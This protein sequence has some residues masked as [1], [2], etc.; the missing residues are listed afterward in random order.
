MRYAKFLLGSNQDVYFRTPG[1]P[2]LLILTGV[3][4][5]DS[6]LGLML[7]QLAM[8]VLMPLLVYRIIAMYNQR[9]GY[10]AA[11]FSIA[12]LV[13]YGFMKAVLTEEL[14]MFALLLAMWVA[15]R[16]FAI[17]LVRYIYV[18]SIIFFFLLLI[19]PVAQYMFAIFL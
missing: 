17:K 19:R 1:Y 4:T 12:S 2:L 9:V 5:F 18:G 11:L 10:Y 16:F 8:G 6:F 14:Y 15:A 13:P 3:F 7:A